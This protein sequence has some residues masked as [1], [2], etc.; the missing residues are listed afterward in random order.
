MKNK[1]SF[2]I[3]FFSILLFIFI[4]SKFINK[5]LNFFSTISNKFVSNDNV[6]YYEK[7][8]VIFENIEFDKNF[9]S[10]S[11]VEFS[12]FNLENR[13]FYSD[14][15]KKELDKYP[16][17]LLEKTVDKMYYFRSLYID[18]LSCG[19]TRDAHNK[20]I[21]FVKSESFHAE[22]SSLFFIQ[23][24]SK[25][26]LSEW[27]SFNNGGYTNNGFAVAGMIV[28]LNYEDKYLKNGFLNRY[29]QTDMENDFNEF[30]KLIY[31][32]DS[33]LEELVIEYKRIA[34]KVKLTKR[35]M[36]DIK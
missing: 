8:P 20:N 29:G 18:G 30:F 11:N 15:I 25:F 24:K 2:V 19:G 10:N 36:K 32:D 31:F 4:I 14:I 35:F 28:A 27:Q 6:M 5:E 34:G 7:I 22:L 21:Y 1:I 33:R 23:N 16:K 13:K 3:L 26:P 9:I 17:E 12:V